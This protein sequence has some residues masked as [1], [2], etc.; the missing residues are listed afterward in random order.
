[1]ADSGPGLPLPLRRR[2]PVCFT[3]REPSFL[4]AWSV[5][6]QAVED[7]LFCTSRRTGRCLR[8]KRWRLREPVGASTRARPPARGASATSA[9]SQGAVLHVVVAPASM[10]VAARVSS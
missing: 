4:S 8:L 6:V 1:M 5:A 2:L 9:A 3:H 10:K 7:G